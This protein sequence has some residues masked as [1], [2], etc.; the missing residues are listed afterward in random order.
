[1]TTPAGHE[2]AGRT[3]SLAP[4]H[5]GELRAGAAL[6]V[7]VLGVAVFITAIGM[8]V[9][10]LTATSGIDPSNPPPNAET[11]GG[12]QIAAGVALFVLGLLL[13][14]GGLGLL[15]GSV[16]P[17][18]P[19]AVLAVATGI[20]AMAG[21]IFVILRGPSDLVLAIALLGLGLGLAGAGLVLLRPRP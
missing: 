8:I 5:L 2:A 12:W 7:S 17:R 15:S 18:I 11:L 6:T 4:P 14:G 13:A 21:A 1:M 20:G 16:R 9:S 19:T 10:G 3:H